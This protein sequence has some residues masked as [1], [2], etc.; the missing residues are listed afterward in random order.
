[1][2]KSQAFPGFVNPAAPIYLVSGAGGNKEHL[3]GIGGG[4]FPEW[5][6]FNLVEYG[7]GE[8]VMRQCF[9]LTPA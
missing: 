7:Y 2:Y 9:Q 5:N 1:M 6:R 3:T 8:Q 4:P